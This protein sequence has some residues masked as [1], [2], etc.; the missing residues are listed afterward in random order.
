MFRR[1]LIWLGVIALTVI[2]Y[3]SGSA[4]LR[5]ALPVLLTSFVAWLF[6]RTLRAGRTPLIARAIA[7]LD[8]PVW[9][10]DPAVARYARRLTLLWATYLFVLAAVVAALA[11][12]ARYGATSSTWMQTV[13]RFGAPGLPLAVAALFIGEFVLR[14]RLLPQAPRHGFFVFVR[15]LVRH[16][17]ALLDE[18][19][20]A[21]ASKNGDAR[22]SP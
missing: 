21:G 9:L 14:R 12:H 15:D 20:L 3:R 1:A 16:W 2:A 17:P 8:G 5:D 4:L 6:A 22:H 18:R 7:A 11:L 19:E 10:A 13:Q